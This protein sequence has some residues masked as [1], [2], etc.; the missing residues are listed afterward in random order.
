MI[1]GNILG[2]HDSQVLWIEN[3]EVM[4]FKGIW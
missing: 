3:I 4:G 1:V 2:N